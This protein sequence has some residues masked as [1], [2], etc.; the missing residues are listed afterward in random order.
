[1]FPKKFTEE[2]RW[3]FNEDAD[4]EIRPTVK[5]KRIV[6]KVICVPFDDWFDT[7]KNV[8]RYKKEKTNE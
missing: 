4:K 2:D 5:A 6:D 7:S 1:M 3:D 8:K